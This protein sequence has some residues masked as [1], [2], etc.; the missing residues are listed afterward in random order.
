MTRV[1]HRHRIFV[2][3]WDPDFG[4]AFV[5]GDF[6]PTSARVDASVELDPERW[7]PMPPEPAELRDVAFVDGVRRID[8][9]VW[10]SDDTEAPRLGLCASCAAGMVASNEIRTV[11]TERHLITSA[12]IA[13]LETTVGCFE[14]RHVEVGSSTELNLEVQNVLRELET[15]V[16]ENPVPPDGES[17]VLIDGPLSKQHTRA[18]ALGYIKTHRVSYLDEGTTRTVLALRAG[19]RSPLFLTTT[20]WKRYS[21][22]LRL[23]GAQE[24]PWAGMVRL[25]VAGT[26]P[27]DEA[28]R[29]VNAAQ[30]LLPRYASVPH[31][32]PRAPQNLFP[33]G[34]LERELRRRLGDAQLVHRAIR[35]AAGA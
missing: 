16:A 26:T 18:G 4:T 28:R 30:A 15:G 22:Y 31:K 9:L 5:P 33:I 32:E 20:A 21:C 23:P 2:E 8:A 10:I 19:E 24:H 3:G 1:G 14:A 11:V 27:L 6:E 12:D 34:G 35:T 17:L 7:K 13:S 25:E 29:L